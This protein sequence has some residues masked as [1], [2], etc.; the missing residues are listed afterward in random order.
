M[1]RSGDVRGFSLLEAMLA[2]VMVGGLLCAAFG[3][4]AADLRA[5]RR[6]A[7]LQIASALAEDL[8][9]RA[10]LAPAT[11]LRE[12]SAGIEGEFDI[13]MDR[14]TWRLVVRPIEGEIDLL[15]LHAEVVWSEGSF[16]FGTRISPPASSAGD[17]A[18]VVSIRAQ[19]IM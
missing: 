14:F 5:S 16:A 2:L 11:Q 6:A 7:D 9:S 10:A 15:D 17:T 12:W 13:P 3:V 19:L 1:L 4:A 8:L 18:G